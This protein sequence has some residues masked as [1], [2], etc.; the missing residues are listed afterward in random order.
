MHA[1][2]AQAVLTA[3]SAD[4]DQVDLCG[5]FG[6]GFSLLSPLGN[7]ELETVLLCS[8]LQP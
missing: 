5:L 8:A 6:L 3:A 7:V 1:V 2:S 4:N